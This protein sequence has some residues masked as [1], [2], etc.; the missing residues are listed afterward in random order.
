MKLASIL[1]KLLKEKDI[2][3]SQLSRSS[4]VPVQTISNWLSGQSPRSITQLKT[5]ADLLG[6]DLD[7]LCFGESKPIVQD[8]NP[9]KDFEE[10]VNCGVFEVVLRKVKK[11]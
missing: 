3:A 7:Y 1:K 2:T 9:I 5:V 10:E 4:G 6:V 11:F 8:K